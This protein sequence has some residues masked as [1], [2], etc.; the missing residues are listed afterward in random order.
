MWKQNE[1]WRNVHEAQFEHLRRLYKRQWLESWRVNADEYIHKYN[2]TKASTLSQWENEMHA[3]DARRIDK[4]NDIKARGKLKAKHRDL[5]REIH[6]REFFHWY[7]RAS[8]R[9]QAMT[10]IPFIPRENI[11]DHIEKELNKY[12]AGKADPY[13]LNFVGQMPVL[14]DGDGNISEVPKSQYVNFVAERPTTSAKAYEAPR[15]ASL[16]DQLTSV[17]SGEAHSLQDV[18]EADAL[19]SA[20]MDEMAREDA[21]QREAGMDTDNEKSEEERMVEKRAYIDRGKQGIRVRNDF[22]SSTRTV[23]ITPQSSSQMTELSGTAA[24]AKKK[25]PPPQGGLSGG[26]AARQRIVD[27]AINKRVSAEQTD[28][29]LHQN[30]AKSDAPLPK[31][32]EVMTNVPKLRSRLK[33]PDMQE[34]LA[35]HPILAAQAGGMTVRNSMNANKK[36]DDE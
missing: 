9:L 35:S 19:E 24:G 2:I 31:V 1:L 12:V 20:V 33:M 32:G 15:E 21:S 5:Y 3:Q 14:E 18:E 26:R 36:N 13:P 6:E 4:S 27:A 28:A 7:E 23:N 34:V 17:V 22:K 16:V 30:L 25:R 29:F 8:E 11:S 10:K